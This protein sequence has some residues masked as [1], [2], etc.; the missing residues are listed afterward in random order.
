MSV[1][2]GCGS[3]EKLCQGKRAGALA[4]TQSAYACQACLQSSAAL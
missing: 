4:L 1:F 3:P 2:Q